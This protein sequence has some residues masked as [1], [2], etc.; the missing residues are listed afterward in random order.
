MKVYFQKPFLMDY[1]NEFIIQDI[2]YNISRNSDEERIEEF[3][4][5]I[6]LY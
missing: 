1:L 5:K 3:S 2:K 4:K 6:Q